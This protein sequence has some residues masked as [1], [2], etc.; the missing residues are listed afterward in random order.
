[1]S[2]KLKKNGIHLN[3][4]TKLHKTKTEPHIEFT[5]IT[6]KWLHSYVLQPKLEKYE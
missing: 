1:M 5:A 2:V 4:H 6:N 3:K